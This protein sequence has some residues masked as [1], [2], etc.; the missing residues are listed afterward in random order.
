MQRIAD[1]LPYSDFMTVGLLLSHAIHG[2]P[3]RQAGRPTAC[4]RTIG[5]TFRSRTCVSGGFRYS[6]IGVLAS[7]LIPPRSGSDWSTSAEKVMI[8]GP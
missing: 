1:A 2:R 8:Y 6:I 5:S 3:P 7:S 4:R